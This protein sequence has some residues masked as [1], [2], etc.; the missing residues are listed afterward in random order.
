MRPRRR[1]HGRAPR[2]SNM[3][4]RRAS[5]SQGAAGS[6]SAAPVF[7]YLNWKFAHQLRVSM[8]GGTKSLP[9]NSPLLIAIA[10]PMPRANPGTNFGAAP[11]NVLTGGYACPV[12]RFPEEFLFHDPLP[13]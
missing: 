8:L 10:S 13:S 9:V 5:R 6:S 4:S 2:R 11:R 7:A 3:I 12:H 1:G